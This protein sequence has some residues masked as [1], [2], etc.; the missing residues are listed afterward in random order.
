MKNGAEK[1]IHELDQKVI[2]RLSQRKY[3]DFF[4][5]L[6]DVYSFYISQLAEFSIEN[7]YGNMILLNE[8][9]SYIQSTKKICN[10]IK[11]M[12]EGY[13]NGNLIQ[14]GKIYNRLFKSTANRISLSSN[15]PKIEIKQDS[16]WYRGRRYKSGMNMKME[17][18][19]HVPFEKRGKIGAN[20]FSVIGYP[21]LYLASSIN[22]CI[23]ENHCT[24]HICISA[25]KPTSGFTVYDFTFFPHIPSE[26]EMWKYLHSYPIKIACSIPVQDDDKENLFIPEYIIPE[27][28]LHG[29]IKQTKSSKLLGIAYTSTN[30][31]TESFT[32][33]SVRRHTNLVIPAV[34][35]G[36]KGFC[37]DLSKLFPL[38]NPI[39]IQLSNLIDENMSSSHEKNLTAMKFCQIK[40]E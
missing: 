25:F 20:R 23:K 21:C 32:K 37:K 18:L 7:I 6:E 33:D 40:E 38:T 1:L 27:Y 13:L 17:D 36:N 19:F 5:E 35:M 15:F 12:I 11:K 39:P 10:E 14:L 2:S 28:V 4:Q 30:I 34:K 26:K 31:F 3:N 9:P 16:I 24:N 22:C 8:V 29:T